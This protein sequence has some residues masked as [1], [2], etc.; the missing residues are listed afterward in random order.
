VGAAAVAPADAATPA[1]AAIPAD[2]VTRVDATTR[3]DAAIQ[4]DAAIRVDAA[5]PADAANAENSESNCVVGRFARV[6]LLYSAVFAPRLEQ[7]LEPGL[8]AVLIVLGPKPLGST[9]LTIRARILP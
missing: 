5:T 3:V 7:S 4:V 2:A 1:D 8:K 9:A 6:S